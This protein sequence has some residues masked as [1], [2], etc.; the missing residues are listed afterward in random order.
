MPMSVQWC[1]RLLPVPFP[2]FD[3]VVDWDEVDAQL[4]E[5]PV[6]MQVSLQL[7][8]FGLGRGGTDLM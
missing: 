3:P 2:V 1:G 4:G 8:S 6:S 7:L 5:T